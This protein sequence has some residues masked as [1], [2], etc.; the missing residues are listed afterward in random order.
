MTSSAAAG[1]SKESKSQAFV[2]CAYCDLPVLGIRADDAPSHP[3]YCCFGC[4]LAHRITNERG[5]EG[6]AAWQLTLIGVAIFL[7]MNVMVFNWVL[8]GQEIFN[9]GGIAE[10]KTASAAVTIFRYISMLFCAVVVAILG[11][12]IA[13]GGVSSLRYRRINT[14]VLLALG[15]LAAFVYSYVSVLRETGSVYFDTVCMILLLVTIGRSMEARAKLNAG[16]ALRSL[17]TLVPKQALLVSK[18]ELVEVPTAELSTGDVIVVKPGMRCA[19]D[20]VIIEGESLLDEHMITGE[21]DASAKKP[22]DSVY[23]GSLNGDGTLRVRVGAGAEGSIL[24]RI[25]DALAEA[26]RGRGRHQRIAD[27]VAA[28]FVPVVIV[29]AIATCVYTSTQLGWRSGVMRA[30]SVLLIACPCALG[31]ATPMA[32]WVAMGRA[33]N[34]GIVIRNVEAFE[35]LAHVQTVLFDK[36][37]TLTTARTQVEQF[38]TASPADSDRG[39]ILALA[40]ALAQTSTHH[41]SEA[42]CRFAAT[43]DTQAA[44]IA[45][46]RTVPGQGVFAQSTDD[47][48]TFYLGSPRFMNAKGLTP[49]ETLAHKIS[50]IE[51]AGSP[52]CCVGW[53]ARIMGVFSFHEDLR[54]DA[55]PTLQHLTDS[56]KQLGVLTGDHQKHGERLCESLNIPVLAELLPADKTEHIKTMQGDGVSVAMVGDGINDAPALAAADVGIAMGCGADVTRESADACLMSNDLSAIPWLFDLSKATVR[57]IKQNLFWAFAYNVGGLGLAATGQLGPVT[58]A[59]AMLV[60]SFLVVANSMRLSRIPLGESITTAHQTVTTG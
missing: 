52:L 42:I 50:E 1:V 7:S 58:A 21:S 19:A 29:L 60:S 15:V 33:A 48:T 36:T 3:V 26:R 28:F 23:A 35:T 38:V 45:D 54:T 44:K 43:S 59:V 20:G 32:I 30:M 53:D 13:A 55:K 10:S 47:S 37:G 2:E 9:P 18:N 11:W 27:R 34:R 49:D 17:E 22:N 51:S 57:V 5:A 6:Q 4:Q 25:V 24:Q 12:P 41:L 39:S 31:V 56:G 46:S 40:R 8:Y 14:D 16:D